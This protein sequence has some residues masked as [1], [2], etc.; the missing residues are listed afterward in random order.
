MET[1]PFSVILASQMILS[2]S[3]SGTAMTPLLSS[4]KHALGLLDNERIH[5]LIE[6]HLAAVLG[7]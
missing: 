5:G 1:F 3:L 7:R 6:K 2:T 4:V